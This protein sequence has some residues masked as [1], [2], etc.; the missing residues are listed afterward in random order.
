MG[1]IWPYPGEIDPALTGQLSLEQR[2]E[3]A[4]EWWEA[5]LLDPTASTVPLTMT[6]NTIHIGALNHGAIQQGSA[7]ATQTVLVGVD[8]DAARRASEEIELLAGTLPEEIAVELRAEIATINAQLRKKAPSAAILRE[9][10]TT[11][12]D[13]ATGAVG[14]AMAPDLMPAVQTMLAALGLN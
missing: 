12:R 13:I 2:V 9:A 14:G 4:V 1:L 6:N 11:L 7:G 8:I 10:G 5:G 3:R